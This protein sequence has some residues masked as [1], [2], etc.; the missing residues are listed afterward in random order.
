[1][2]KRKVAVIIGSKS[3]LPQCLVGLRVLENSQKQE[4]ITIM[5]NDVL[6]SSIHRATRETLDFLTAMSGADQPPD[7]IITGAGMA[8][9]LTG[10]CDAYLRYCLRDTKIV[11]VGVAFYD[12]T[13]QDNNLAAR[14]S[15]SQVP[16]T[17]VI[18][19]DDAG[20]FI[21]SDGFRRACEFAIKGELPVLTLPEPKPQERLRFSEAIAIAER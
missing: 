18:Y 6:V 13:C 17:Q 16:D 4:E 10:M 15:I 1:L 2:E 12:R 3:D 19:S 7:I 11:I 20:T 5:A 14:L 21:G 9:H 8:N